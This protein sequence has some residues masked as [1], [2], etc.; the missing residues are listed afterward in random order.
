MET[1]PVPIF[2]TTITALSGFEPAAQ[3]EAARAALKALKARHGRHARWLAACDAHTA[4]LQAWAQENGTTLSH[5]YQTAWKTHPELSGPQG[6]MPS[7][8]SGKLQY[9]DAGHLT[10]MLGWDPQQTRC[11]TM[12]D[13]AALIAAATAVLPAR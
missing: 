8:E 4:A 12:A 11:N 5:A 7:R 2:P 3:L 6:R 10:R 13:L 1:I 9:S